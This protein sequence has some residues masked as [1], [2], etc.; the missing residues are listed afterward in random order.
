MQDVQ[1]LA[2]DFNKIPLDTE[3]LKQA[4]QA[5]DQGEFSQARKILD[6]KLLAKDQKNVKR[7]STELS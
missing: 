1:K 5:F 4:K 2:A 3:R 6:S 7:T